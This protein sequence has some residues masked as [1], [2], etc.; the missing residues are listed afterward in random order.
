MRT[1]GA[2]L[3]MLGGVATTASA[4]PLR[5]RADALAQAQAPV[6][7][8]ALQAHG[9]ASDWL[10]AEALVWTA[11]DDGDV[12]G[13]ALVIV[14]RLRDP[15]G[16]G[17]L[18]LG[19][20]VQTTGALRPLHV[21]GVS[22][23]A[24]LPWQRIRVEA[25]GGVPV[26]P[27]FSA[28]AYDWAAGA[29]LSRAIGRSGSVG[30]AYLQR[31]ESGDLA[32]EEVGV[33]AAAALRPWLDA[34]GRLAYDRID[35]GISEARAAIGT[36]RGA[37]R[38]ELYGLSRSPSRMMPATSL[39]SVLGDVPSRLIGSS[40]RWRAAPRLDVDGGLGIRFIDGD[41]GP[42]GSIGTT[43]R[44]DDRG[45]GA[46][47]LQLRRETAPDGDWTGARAA[48]RVPIASGWTAAAEAELAIA[49]DPRDRGRVWPWMLAAL[50]WIPAPSWEVA[51]AV[52]ASADPATEMRVDVL[53]RLSRAWDG[54]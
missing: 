48:A 14:A 16:R 41:T 33:D 44:L 17:E 22:G 52:E 35:P 27:A 34:S 38:G 4:E 7:L 15:G 53:A 23:L 42:S 43:L 50:R 24:R 39:F 49:D 1:A 13:D 19:R 20:F 47:S 28:D 5:L 3:A 10:S 2:V 37:W 46:L 11:G 12:D 18:R 26:E 45:A 54:L 8:L 29:R 31:R 9:D 6:G 21:D 30:V 40:V 25:F 51:A 36:R 32:D